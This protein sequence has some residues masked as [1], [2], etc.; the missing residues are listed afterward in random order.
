MLLYDFHFLNLSPET[1]CTKDLYQVFVLFNLILSFFMD[2]FVTFD[3]RRTVNFCLLDFLMAVI[4]L[5]SKFHHVDL[6]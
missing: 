5:Y 1:I 2:F 3:V 6:Q 4:L